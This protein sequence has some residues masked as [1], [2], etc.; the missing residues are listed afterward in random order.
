[1]G[2]LIIV[3]P[4]LNHNQ[5]RRRVL[6]NRRRKSANGWFLS[7]LTVAVGTFTLTGNAATFQIQEPWSVTPFSETGNAATFQIQM[8]ESVGVFTLTGIAVNFVIITPIPFPVSVGTFTLNG[9]PV[10][11]RTCLPLWTGIADPV[12]VWSTQIDSPTTW[13][14]EDAPTTAWDTPNCCS[15]RT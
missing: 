2:R 13:A 4:D 6:Q 10:T 15:E 1:M 9:Q 14:G 12:A 5:R 3:G 7:P 8:L 11:F